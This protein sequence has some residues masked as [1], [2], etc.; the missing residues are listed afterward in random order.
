MSTSS[1]LRIPLTL[2]TSL[3]Q[4]NK[5]EVQFSVHSDDL[6]QDIFIDK[7]YNAVDLT[8]SARDGTVSATIRRTEIPRWREG[9]EDAKLFAHFWKGERFVASEDCGRI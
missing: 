9:G 4:T 2:P 1:T 3:L 7:R 5:Y 6:D 8:R